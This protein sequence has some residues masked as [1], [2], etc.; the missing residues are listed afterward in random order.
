MNAPY[1]QHQ[2][3]RRELK[4]ERRY[5]VLAALDLL[6]GWAIG[7]STLAVSVY[8][9]GKIITFFFPVTLQWLHNVGL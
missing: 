3:F 7:L 5:P 1:L 6:L 9:V 2:K 8:A 4:R